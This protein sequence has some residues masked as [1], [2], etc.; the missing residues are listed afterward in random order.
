MFL[1]ESVQI[2]KKGSFRAIG[3][4][5]V[6]IWLLVLAI[7]SSIKFSEVCSFMSEIFWSNLVLE[8]FR[9]CALFLTSQTKSIFHWLCC[10]KTN[11]CTVLYK[12]GYA[13]KGGKWIWYDNQRSIRLTLR[14]SVG[15]SYGL[16]YRYWWFS[17]TL[18]RRQKPTAS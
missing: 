3:T 6:S 4:C 16:C 15:W 8:L 11:I 17:R 2:F 7:I 18:W 9:K 10:R 13:T 12:C 5:I 14:T 1:F